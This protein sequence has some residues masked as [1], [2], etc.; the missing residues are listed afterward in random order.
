EAIRAQG[1]RVHGPWGTFVVRPGVAEE[2][3][4]LARGSPFDA[5]LVCV[6]AG[7]VR[8]VAAALRPL[9]GEGTV[10]VPL[11]NGVEA[12]E[13]LSTELG[14]GRVAGGLC[15]VFAWREG[16]GEVRTTGTPLQIT[17]GELKGPVTPR[18]TRLAEAIRG[19]GAG[20]VLADD[21]VAAAWEKF[22]FIDP[23]GSVGAVTRAP[24]G[25]MR[26]EPR[27]RALLV[28]AVEEVD[29]LARARGVALA[30]DAVARTLARYDE[31]PAE[32]TASMQRDVAAGRPSELHEQTGAV[33]RLGEA[34]GANV[35]VH[36]FLYAA[37]LP[38]EAAA[39]RAGS[40]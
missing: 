19:A 2:P 15:H 22:L 7:Q 37:L 23:F 8:E 12:A 4:G 29:A 35:P 24:I 1:L 28:A 33:V 3:A 17:L 9:V 34:A 27:T 36:R 38:Q 39:R 31:L 6:K 21:V 25:V 14:A 40:G 11:Q 5:V 13:A 18:L 10:V 16:P 26:S 20:A 32:A 30:A